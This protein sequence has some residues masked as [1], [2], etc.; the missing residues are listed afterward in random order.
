[1]KD[2]E[3]DTSRRTYRLLEL[4]GPEKKEGLL[5]WIDDFR[6]A[7]VKGEITH[8]MTD[9]HMADVG[10]SDLEIS[11]EGVKEVRHIIRAGKAYDIELVQALS[12]RIMDKD[13]AMNVKRADG[14]WTIPASKDKG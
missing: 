9:H 6:D 5:K 4:E 12:V 8:V 14:S 11:D 1:M 3:K 13:Y 10:Y 2:R 7:V